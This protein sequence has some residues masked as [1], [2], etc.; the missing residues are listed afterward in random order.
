[1]TKQLFAP[2]RCRYLPIVL[3]RQYS[4]TAGKLTVDF[5]QGLT[6]EG[7]DAEGPEALNGS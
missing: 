3:N 4:K 6:I 2:S 5:T 1:M 7:L